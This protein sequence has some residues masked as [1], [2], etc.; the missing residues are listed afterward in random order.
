[1][2]KAHRAVPGL[3]ALVAV[4]A[5]EVGPA[6]LLLLPLSASKG[7][8]GTEGVFAATGKADEATIPERYPKRVAAAVTEEVTSRALAT[9]VAEEV[10]PRVSE[11]VI[12][13]LT[14]VKRLVVLGLV[15]LG[16]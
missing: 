14:K 5:V 9:A 4:E 15:D 8:R 12:Q 7:P 13:G 1:M 2:S 10:T 16:L 6:V 11:K 3:G